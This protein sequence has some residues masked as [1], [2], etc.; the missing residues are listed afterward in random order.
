M[1]RTLAIQ[2]QRILLPAFILFVL[3]QVQAQSRVINQDTTEQVPLFFEKEYP[4]NFVAPYFDLLLGLSTLSDFG[5]TS[6]GPSL[7]IKGG[8]EV[9]ESLLVGSGISAISLENWQLGILLPLEF[10]YRTQN[11]RWDFRSGIGYMH[12]PWANS[13]Y[14]PQERRGRTL[15]LDAYWRPSISRRDMRF[16]IALGAMMYDFGDSDIF[17]QDC[18][19]CGLE[20]S[21]GPK[22]TTQLRVG[23]G[24]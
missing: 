6:V 14:K 3:F 23:I 12:I 4:A 24:F 15:S 5:Y 20:R 18:F 17:N 10:G 11:E 13:R 7:A 16:V 8:V 2:F 21:T 22:I 19:G 9:K 1:K